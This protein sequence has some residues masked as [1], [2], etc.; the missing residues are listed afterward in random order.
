M[1][2]YTLIFV[3]IMASTLSCCKKKQEEQWKEPTDVRFKFD[4]NRTPMMGG[5]LIFTGGSFEMGEFTFDGDKQSGQGDDYYFHST[6]P[7]GNNITF[8]PTSP[9]PFLDFDIPQ[10]TFTTIRIEFESEG[11]SGDDHIVVIGE[12][13]HSVT[14]VVTPVRLELEEIELYSVVATGPGGGSQVTLNSNASYTPIIR[15]DPVHWFQTV[16]VGDMDNATTYLV[17]G[18]PTI[19]ISDSQNEDIFDLVADRVDEATEVE[20]D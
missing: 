10:G 7:G 12:Y 5:N 14:S 8:S 15:L 1:R 16:P 20:F 6:Y 4:I 2:T 17:S 9:V 3:L 13:T 18:I 19:V 11:A